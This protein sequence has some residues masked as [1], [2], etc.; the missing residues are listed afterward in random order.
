MRV[1]VLPSRPGQADGRCGQQPWRVRTHGH[2]C[3]LGLDAPLLGSQQSLCLFPPITG[4][5]LDASGPPER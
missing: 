2:G 1:Q 3:V 4:S 5:G